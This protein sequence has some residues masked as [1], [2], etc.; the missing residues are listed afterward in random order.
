[1]KMVGKR[2]NIV[3]K[4][5]YSG[6]ESDNRIVKKVAK[7]PYPNPNKRNPHETK[8]NATET[9]PKNESSKRWF[10]G[11]NTLLV[12][13]ENKNVNY[14]WIYLEMLS[15]SEQRSK[16]LMTFHHTD[17]FTRMASFKFPEVFKSHDLERK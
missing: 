15:S 5:W 17:W 8:Q 9:R 4:S 2:F 11:V 7:S 3:S 10:S 1:M 12:S 13:T 6:D 14:F 16:P